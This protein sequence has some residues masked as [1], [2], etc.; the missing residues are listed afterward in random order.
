MD[1]LYTTEQ[2]SDLLAVEQATVQMW[3]RDGKL[4][5]AKIGA[6]YLIS[7]ADLDA[8][9][10]SGYKATEKKNKRKK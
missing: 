10:A 5:A 9:L 2:V 3:V 1:Q 6:R 4:K 7:Q 8:F